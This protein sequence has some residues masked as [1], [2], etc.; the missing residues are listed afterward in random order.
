MGKEVVGAGV[1]AGDGAGEIQ[2][3][4]FADS[5]IPK[6]TTAPQTLSRTNPQKS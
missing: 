5:V 3:S 2:G 6:A 1:G 4:G